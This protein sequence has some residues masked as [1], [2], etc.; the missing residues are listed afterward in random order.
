MELVLAAAYVSDTELEA[1]WR[2]ALESGLSV[3]EGVFQGTA[4]V[5][6]DQ[7]DGKT[8]ISPTLSVRLQIAPSSK[9]DV[10]DVAQGVIFVNDRIEVRGEGFL[11]GGEEGNSVA[12]LDGCFRQEGQGSCKPI[13]TAHVIASPTQPNDRTRIA[14]PFAPNV[15][16]IHPGSF[17]GSVVISNEHGLA[18]DSI[19]YKTD[20]YPVRFDLTSTTIFNLTPKTASL[21]QYVDIE[22]GGFV[23]VPPDGSDPGLALT[24]LM[25]SGEFKTGAANP[26]PVDVTLVPE[27]V[28]GNLVRYVLSE[29]DDELGQAIDLRKTTGDFSGTIQPVIQYEQDSVVGAAHHT[30]FR[31][32]SVKQVVWV[33]F[34]ASYVGSLR[35]FGLRAVDPMIRE[36]VLEV[37]ARDYAG[38]NM[39]FRQEKPAD[40]AL[41]AQVDLSGPDP[42]GYGL[43]GYD[44]TPGKDVGNDRLYDKIGGV[45]ATTQEDGYAGYGGVFVESFFGFSE[46][47]GILAKRL[48]GANPFFDSIFDPFRPDVGGRPVEAADLSELIIPKLSSGD[49]CPAVDKTDRGMQIAC[50]IW[51]LGSMIGSTMTHEVGHSLGLADPYGSEFHNLGDGHNRLMDSGSFRP[52]LERAE[53]L[54][55]GPAVFCEEDYQYLR[56]VL[57]HPDPDPAPSRPPCW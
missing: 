32:E 47:P 50:A 9:P 15:A 1:S 19:T 23:G 27:F 48:E 45:N 20:S 54:G 16:G 31:I 7:D 5:A 44:N 55:Y 3:K 46:H 24:T 6:T 12:M 40:Y 41:F 2:G 21:G 35:H 33:N 51:A 42:N 13:P 56:F 17:E 22:G 43:L 29:K 11:L 28:N 10:F 4:V 8:H 38:T 53:I 26:I 52:F 39:E 25:L 36:R 57:P 49:E 37:A 34:V 14:F 30:S 18:A